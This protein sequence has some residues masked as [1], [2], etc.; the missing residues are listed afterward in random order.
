[1]LAGGF[2]LSERDSKMTD[3]RPNEETDNALFA[4]HRNFF[5]V[6]KWTGDGLSIDGLLYA[7]QQP[8]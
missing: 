5:K 6:E 3:D 1:M 4:D 7:G 8:G 2:S